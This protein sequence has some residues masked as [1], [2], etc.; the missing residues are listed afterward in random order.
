[1]V[2]YDNASACAGKHAKVYFAE[3]RSL[4][5]LPVPSRFCSEKQSETARLVCEVYREVP[6]HGNPLEFPQLQFSNPVAL[7]VDS[8]PLDWMIRQRPF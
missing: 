3:L 7:Q 6:W 2:I 4:I 5:H 1:M 8:L